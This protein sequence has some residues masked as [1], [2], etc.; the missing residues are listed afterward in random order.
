MQ[1][2]EETPEQD[3]KPDFSSIALSVLFTVVAT[4]VMFSWLLE[5][6][7]DRHRA[8]YQ[9]PRREVSGLLGGTYYQPASVS[10]FDLDRPIVVGLLALLIAYPVVHILVGRVVSS[11]THRLFVRMC[12]VFNLVESEQALDFWPTGCDMLLGAIWPFTILFIPLLLIALFFG[13]L[14]RSIW[15]T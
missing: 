8:F 15:N 12:L 11:I 4:V 7:K 10:F 14:Y 5:A 6:A 9:L 3:R 13:A 2:P 1:S